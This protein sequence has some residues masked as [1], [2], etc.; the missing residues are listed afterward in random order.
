MAEIPYGRSR[1]SGFLPKS[2]VPLRFKKNIVLQFHNFFV[3]HKQK[4]NFLEWWTF[5]IFLQYIIFNK[6]RFA[7]NYYYYYYYYEYRGMR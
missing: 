1:P 6:A 4:L 7:C 3:N 2:I 5:A